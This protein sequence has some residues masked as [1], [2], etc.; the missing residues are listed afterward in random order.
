M[1]RS[2]TLFVGG[3]SSSTR[4]KDVAYEFERYGRLIRCDMPFGPQGAKGFAFVEFEDERDAEDAKDALDGRRV[5]GRVVTIQWSKRPPSRN[6]RT[7]GVRDY[8]PPRRDR[9]RDRS[10]R[11]RD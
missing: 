3:L 11:D 6:W 1:P 7:G 2:A 4:P 10:P 5:D 8:S 9:Y